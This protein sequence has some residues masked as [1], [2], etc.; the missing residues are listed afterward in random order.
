[1]KKIL[2]S[3]LVALGLSLFA[4]ADEKIIIGATS[5]PHAEILEAVKP[6]LKKSGYDLEIKEFFDYSLPNLALEDEDLDANYFQHTPYLTEFNKNKGTHLVTTVAVHI[7]PLGIYS[8]KVKSLDELKDGDSVAIP[9]DP[10][11]E[12]RALNILAK[13]G[14]I[15]LNDEPLKTLIDITENP[16]NLNFVEIEAAQ[17]PRSL[18][19]ITLAAINTNYALSANLNPL[20]DSILLEDKDSPYV[21]Y[22]V[23]KEGHE[24]DKKIKALNDAV[25]SEDVKKFI[26]EKYQGAV[27]PVF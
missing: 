25:T 14:L 20:K 3:S 9:N 16:K 22:I 13:A 26:I 5:V 6:V 15:K 17:I 4:N 18:D 27:L 12:D 21:N 2:I 7:E 24:N 1:M 8:K 23:V 19:D 10:T 11:N